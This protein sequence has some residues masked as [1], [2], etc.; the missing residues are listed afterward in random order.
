[1]LR[2]QLQHLKTYCAHTRRRRPAAWQSA[3]SYNVQAFE[4]FLQ[5]MTTYRPLLLRIKAAYDPVLRDAMAS[6]YDNVHMK[7]ELAQAPAKLV[8]ECTAA[9]D[10]VWLLCRTQGICI[11]AMGPV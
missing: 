9:D 7:S 11:I 8:S 10:P 6:T 5:S 3:I 4:G 2:L 1:M